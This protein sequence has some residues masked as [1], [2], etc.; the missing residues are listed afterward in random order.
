M[1]LELT[2][3]ILA[4]S[5]ACTALLVWFEKRPTEIGRVRLLP[6]TPLIFLSLMVAILMIVHV[7]NLMGFVTGR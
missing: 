1:S 3:V 2:L 5:I 6:T 7:V 4:A